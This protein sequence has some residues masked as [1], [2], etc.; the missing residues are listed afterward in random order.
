MNTF[1][2]I[3]CKDCALA[4]TLDCKLNYIDKQRCIFTDRPPWFFCADAQSKP[5]YKPTHADIIRNKSDSELA[6]FLFNVEMEGY[7]LRG[8]EG[9]NFSEANLKKWWSDYLRTAYD[10]DIKEG[11]K[12]NEL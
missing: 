3:R 8:E 9:N 7:N 12:T 6:D 11:S 5:E 2:I 4:N 1:D 10:A